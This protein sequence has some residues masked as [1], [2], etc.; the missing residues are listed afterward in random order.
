M[1]LVGER[2]EWGILLKLEENA[3]LG[4]CSSPIY[5]ESSGMDLT[6]REGP[7]LAGFCLL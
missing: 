7:L 6:V 3:R 5:G 4:G 1:F 2:R